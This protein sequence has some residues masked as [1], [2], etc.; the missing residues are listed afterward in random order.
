MAW[1][2]GQIF[3]FIKFLIRKNQSAG[4]TRDEFQL[5]W[6]AESRG[7]MDDLLGRFQA[8]TTG[9]TIG[10]DTGLIQNETIMTKLTPFTK[11]YMLAATGGNAPKP[12][13]LIYTLG[14]RAY[15]STSSVITYK[16]KRINH[17]QIWATNDDVIDPPSVADGSYFYTEYL[18]Y[19]SFLPT[20][21]TAAALD[22]V[23]EVR[24]IVWAY[25]L[26]AYGRQQYDATASVQPQWDGDSIVEITKRTLK[27]LGVS[28][29]DSEFSQFGS[30]TIATG[31]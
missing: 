3:N 16:A 26:T 17:D 30:A 12:D 29:K 27:S 20:S 14:I 24:D 25:T 21:V 6:N 9:K 23:T 28:F 15:A 31:D 18:N 22:Y 4:I 2:T 19:F 11:P 10:Q 5:A 7:F 8:R 1:N 13:D